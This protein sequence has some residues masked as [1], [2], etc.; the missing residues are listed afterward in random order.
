LAIASPPPAGIQRAPT[1]T[2]RGTT[3][4]SGPPDRFTTSTV[5][6][7]A[8]PAAAR[9]SSEPRTSQAVA[10]SVGSSSPAAASAAAARGATRRTAASAGVGRRSGGRPEVRCSSTAREALTPNPVA[11]PRTT[12]GDTARMS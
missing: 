8:V 4:A 7:G 3:D 9:G 5:T 2:G 6:M 12:A 11:A 10:R 1:L